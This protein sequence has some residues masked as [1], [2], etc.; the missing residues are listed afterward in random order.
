MHQNFGKQGCKIHATYPESLLR[1]KDNLYLDHILLFLFHIQIQR[2]IF[3]VHLLWLRT[4]VERIQ[5]MTHVNMN[6]LR[7]PSLRG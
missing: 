6:F 3:I 7:N 1:G 4:Y 5:T 2:Q